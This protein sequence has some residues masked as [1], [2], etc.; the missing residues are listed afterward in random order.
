MKKLSTYLFL[1]LFSLSAPSFANDIRD[2]EIDG[3]K[4]YDNIYDIL[5]EVII[6]TSFE[7]IKDSKLYSGSTEFPWL[8]IDPAEIIDQSNVLNNYDFIKIHYKKKDNLI[9]LISGTTYYGN[10]DMRRCI[11]DLN[12]IKFKFDNIFKSPLSRNVTGIIPH[13]STRLPCSTH[14]SVS[15]T[16]PDF[17]IR[18]IC[19]DFTEYKNYKGS[20]NRRIRL[21]VQGYTH[22]LGTWINKNNK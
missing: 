22:E 18:I 6:S 2:Y 11:N 10:F 12:N 8:L 4:I 16:Y 5:P 14:K 9:H 20:K 21:E 17:G 15:Y 7:K 1:I 3:V 13:T 19:Y